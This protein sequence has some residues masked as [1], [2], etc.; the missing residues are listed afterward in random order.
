MDAD[1][2]LSIFEQHIC[3][4]SFSDLGPLKSVF[5]TSERV[6]MY[7]LIAKIESVTGSVVATVPFSEYVFLYRKF[8]SRDPEK[9][10]NLSATYILS[11]VTENEY[12][13]AAINHR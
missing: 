5:V 10:S 9:S 8:S 12:M 3:L 11:F 13:T 4:D 6:H 7:L 2:G 1:S